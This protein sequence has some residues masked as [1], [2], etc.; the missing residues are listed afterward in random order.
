MAR[1]D[2]SVSC[3]RQEAAAQMGGIPD[4]QWP[5]CVAVHPRESGVHMEGVE[6]NQARQLSVAPLSEMQPALVSNREDA[7]LP[8][9]PL[10]SRPAASVRA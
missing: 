1:G 4:Q 5:S 10:T 7:P 8:S 6:R 3:K 9:F 2:T